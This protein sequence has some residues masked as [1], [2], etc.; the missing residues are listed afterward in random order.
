MYVF[1]EDTSLNHPNSASFKRQTRPISEEL[2]RPNVVGMKRQLLPRPPAP[3]TT[4]KP[5]PESFPGKAPPRPP[6]RGV[7][8]GQR[9]GLLASRSRQVP[10]AF[11]YEETFCL[12]VVKN[13]SLKCVSFPQMPAAQ[14]C[15][16]RQAEFGTRTTP[17][18]PR[19]QGTRPLS[20]QAPPRRQARQPTALTPGAPS[21]VLRARRTEDASTVTGGSGGVGGEGRGGGILT[22]RWSAGSQPWAAED[23]Q[24]QRLTFAHGKSDTVLLTPHAPY[25]RSLV[26]S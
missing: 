15:E 2:Q 4:E 5:C 9:S 8:G 14:P 3:P 26:D 25:I 1:L 16:Q 11:L 7:L 20:F 22:T 12:K 24:P 13:K 19:G 10:A 18:P 17:P 23:H 21:R 6:P